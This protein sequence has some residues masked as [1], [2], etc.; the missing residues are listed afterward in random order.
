MGE[1]LLKLSSSFASN[2]AQIL[3]DVMGPNEHE[4]AGVRE[5]A[6]RLA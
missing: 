5:S 3:G 1:Q 6:A 4:N 2:G